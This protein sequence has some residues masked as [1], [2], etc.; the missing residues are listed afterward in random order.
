[1]KPRFLILLA[2]AIGMAVYFANKKNSPPQKQ[3][4]ELTMISEDPDAQPNGP[5]GGGRLLYEYPPPPGEELKE[6]AKFDVR[7]EVDGSGKKNRLYLFV[8][9]Q[10]GYYVETLEI[11]AWRKGPKVTG[12]EDSPLAPHIYKNLYIKANETLR[13]CM[14]IVP[15]ELRHVH[16]N[17]GTSAD[18]EAEVT[19]CG[20]ARDK[21][22]NPLPPTSGDMGL[23]D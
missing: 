16:G 6:K 1:M 11:T 2:V 23:C 10:H 5:Q 18:W 20:R 7:V 4:N 15:A 3:E 8:S 14:E 12:P 9:E 21:N 17:I 13:T 22:P 19:R